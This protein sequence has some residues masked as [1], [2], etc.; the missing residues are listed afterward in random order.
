MK[1][2]DPNVVRV[3]VG[4]NSDVRNFLIGLRSVSSRGEGQFKIFDRVSNS[5]LS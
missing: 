2:D 4:P 1:A 3:G 5:I